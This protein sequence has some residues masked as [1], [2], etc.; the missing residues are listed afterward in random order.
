MENV[1]KVNGIG[2]KQVMENGGA[3][4]VSAWTSGAGRHTK[5]RPTPP[6]CAE[7]AIDEAA[8]LPGTA[9]KAAR[10]ILK[11]YP[12]TQRVIACVDVRNAN[13]ALRKV[14]AEA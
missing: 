5:R 6:F 3:V 11:N 9:G 10:K 7:L 2:L 14:F 12:L 13:K 8:K 4:M 1:T